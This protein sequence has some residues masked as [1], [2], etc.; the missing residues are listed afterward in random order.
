VGRG[1]KT[2]GPELV[3]GAEGSEAAKTRLKAILEAITG[4]KTIAEASASVGMGEAMFHRLK[5]RVIQA[6]VE[7]L[8]PR[9]L[10]RIPAALVERTEAEELAERVKKLERE[11]KAAEVRAE[12]AVAMPHLRKGQKKKRRGT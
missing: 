9:P 5:T 4:G 2:S 7:S 11:L 8:E 12:I 1:R 3:E 6:A 10:G